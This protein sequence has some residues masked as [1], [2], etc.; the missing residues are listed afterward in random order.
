MDEWS[1]VSCEEQLEKLK[2]QESRSASVT[3]GCLV[4][5]HVLYTVVILSPAPMA[6]GESG[7]KELPDVS[8]EGYLAPRHPSIL[9]AP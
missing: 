7:G 1:S 3:D 8:G 4:P 9:T 2:S 6:R 5:V